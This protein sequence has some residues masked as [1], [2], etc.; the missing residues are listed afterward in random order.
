MFKKIMVV[1]LVALFLTACGGNDNKKEAPKAEPEKITEVGS[2]NFYLVNESGSTKDSESIEVM[3]EKDTSLLQIGIETEGIDG[4]LVS[5]I[6]IDGDLA[7]KEQLSDSQSALDLS[8][9]FLKPGDHQVVLKQYPD[10]DENAEP[11]TVKLANYKITE[12]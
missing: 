7:T 1:A 10:N 9:E 5:Y 4:S 8:E 6:Y 3:A 12:L 2:G 11:V